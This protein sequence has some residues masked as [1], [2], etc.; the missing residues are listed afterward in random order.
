[1][2]YG[3]GYLRVADF[4]G[5]GGVVVTGAG[6]GVGVGLGVTA[7]GVVVTGAGVGVGAGLGVSGPGVGDGVVDGGGEPPIWRTPLTLT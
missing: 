1:M 2:T 5:A 3:F 7:G 6:V 4:L